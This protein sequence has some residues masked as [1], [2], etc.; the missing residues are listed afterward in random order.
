MTTVLPPQTVWPDWLIYWTLVNFLKPFATIN[1]PK[2]PTFL[3]NFCKGVKI[4]HFSSKIIFGQLL[5][6]FGNFFSGHTVPK[7]LIAS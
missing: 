4:Y 1:L 2:S 7:Q 5:E 6:M 3:G